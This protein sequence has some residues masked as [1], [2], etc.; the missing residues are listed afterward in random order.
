[1]KNSKYW[2]MGEWR[3]Y[4]DKIT[5]REFF[6]HPR[7]VAIHC[8]TEAKANKLLKEFDRVGARWGDGSSY[9]AHNNYRYGR[10]TIYYNDFTYCYI[11][12]AEKMDHVVYS[13]E[14]VIF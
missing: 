13:F 3:S 9:L 5:V 8:D 1:M 6:D 12:Y 7:V 2:H 14:D 10:D 4:K 11:G